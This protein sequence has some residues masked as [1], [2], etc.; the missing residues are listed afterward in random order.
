MATITV[1]AIMKRLLVLCALTLQMASGCGRLR[2][3]KWCPGF[4]PRRLPS[5]GTALIMGGEWH[6]VIAASCRMFA[7]ADITPTATGPVSRR[8]SALANPAPL[9]IDDLGATK[10]GDERAMRAFA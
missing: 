10:E 5:G 4:R 3:K 1:D 7:P 9:D 8:R 2:P 6:A